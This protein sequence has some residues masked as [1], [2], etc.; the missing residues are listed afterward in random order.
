M[1]LPLH[2]GKPLGMRS[3]APHL[4]RVSAR[5]PCSTRILVGCLGARPLRRSRAERLQ[6]SG[7][8]IRGSAAGRRS[9]FYLKM[10][11]R[12]R[13]AAAVRGDE[14]QHCRIC[15]A[16]P[17]GLGHA[18]AVRLE[19]QCGEAIARHNLVVRHASIGSSI[20]RFRVIRDQ[21]PSLR[22]P[23]PC[24]GPARVGAAV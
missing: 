16:R 19:H 10:G 24:D 1:V 5:G 22:R 3:L 14:P 12:S 17:L 7:A 23:M 13:R 15:R 20:V 2:V 11:H 18:G 6:G 4:H 21:G 9:P 8:A